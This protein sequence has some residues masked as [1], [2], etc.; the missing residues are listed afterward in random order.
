MTGVQTCA[1]PILGSDS[2]IVTINDNTYIASTKYKLN[3]PLILKVL[4]SSGIS[5]DYMLYTSFYPEFTDFKLSGYNAIIVRNE[6]S[7]NKLKLQITVPAA[8][9]VSNVTP[10]FT[11]AT[12]SDKVYINGEEQISGTSRV[13]FTQSVTY[14][15]VSE[16]DG[17]P[18]LKIE[19][20]FEVEIIFQTK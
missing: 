18:D 15:I 11:T 10:T 16:V 7:Y 20:N 9:D 5:K 6:Y 14:N 3:E 8:T 19:T 17:R 4:S 2:A 1:L 13:D 12:S